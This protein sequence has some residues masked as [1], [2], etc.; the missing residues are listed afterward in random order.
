MLA[1]IIKAFDVVSNELSYAA[2]VTNL[3][4]ELEQVANTL[5]RAVEERNEYKDKYES[6]QGYINYLQGAYRE[7][8]EQRTELEA[9][10]ERLHEQ[11]KIL[12]GENAK[13]SGQ[14]LLSGELREK[15][16]ISKESA[17]FYSGENKKLLGT[18]QAL[19]SRI[20]EQYKEVEA[21]KAENQ[22]LKDWHIAYQSLLKDYYEVFDRQREFKR[23]LTSVISPKSLE[24]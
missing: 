16:K 1:R 3:W 14:K 4:S 19:F 10:N 9:E 17:N 18:A 22:K 24:L 23:M 8:S 7:A 5:S 15:L 21:L 6:E 13:S 20:Y 11:I 2:Q 12:R